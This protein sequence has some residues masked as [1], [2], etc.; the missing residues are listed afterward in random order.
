MNPADGRMVRRSDGKWDLF[1]DYWE[2]IEDYPVKRNTKMRDPQKYMNRNKNNI[3][4]TGANSI[5]IILA[6]SAKSVG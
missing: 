5:L 3:I 6:S 4:C 2:A 1:D